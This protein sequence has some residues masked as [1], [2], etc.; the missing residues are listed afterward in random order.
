ML[1]KPEIHEGRF[2]S[3]KIVERPSVR[4]YNPHYRLFKRVI[5][6]FLCLILAP[7]A[8]LITLFLAV[9][10]RFDSPGPIFFVQER[11]GK[12]GKPFKILKF[13]TM[14]HSIDKS[15]HREYMKAFV[16]GII[17]EVE[18]G[19]AVFKPTAMGQI[20]RIGRILRKTSLDELP[21]LINVFSGEMSFVGPRP[22]VSWEVEEYRGWHQERLEVLPGITGLAQVRGRSGI[23]FDE[24][25]EYDIEYIAKQSLKFDL[26]IMWWTV[27]SV[28]AGRGAS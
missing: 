7:L 21:Q 6:I 25:V 11:A 20:T 1:F 27:I 13:R 26:Q 23:V 8:V 4:L 14:H 17:T 5:D 28:L 9:A 18:G 24:I 16:N 22:N 2:N 19:D 3:W 10:I 12:G 15:A